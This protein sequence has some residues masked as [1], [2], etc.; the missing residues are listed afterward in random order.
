MQAA[1]LEAYLHE[2]L[3]I[4]QAMGVRVVSASEESIRLRAPL[5]PNINH[6]DTVFGGSATSLALFAAWSLVHTRLEA[7]G[8]TGRLVIQRH[9][10][11]FD[12]PMAGD[13]EAVSYLEPPDGWAPFMR[14]LTHKGR[15]RLRVGA[16]VEVAD[17]KAGVF[18]GQ[19]VALRS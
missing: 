12:L 9:T 19:F 18:S 11:S 15:A 17:Q 4:S 2:H 3:P 16:D 6:R 1:A 5:A 10:M 14:G 13:F 7:E 8:F